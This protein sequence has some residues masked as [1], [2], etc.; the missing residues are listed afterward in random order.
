[1]TTWDNLSLTPRD[2]CPQ[3]KGMCKGGR[4]REG[5]S[6]PGLRPPP[7][8]P[9]LLPGPWHS[10]GMPLPERGIW[11]G[12]PLEAG[13]PAREPLVASSEVSRCQDNFI[14]T[15]CHP[16]SLSAPYLLLWAV[17]CSARACPALEIP[18]GQQTRHTFPTMCSFLKGAQPGTCGSPGHLHPCLKLPGLLLPVH[19]YSFPR[20]WRASDLIDYGFQSPDLELGQGAE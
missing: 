13:T 16:Q 19:C 1:M 2:M 7:A 20:W 15:M 12:C 4:P 14:A 3:G 6:I 17:F 11:Q 10:P 18:R 9:E 8:A 5:P